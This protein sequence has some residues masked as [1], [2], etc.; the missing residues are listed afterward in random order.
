MNRPPIGQPE[1]IEEGIR[2]ILAPN[3]GPMIHWGTNTWIVGERDVAV[4]DPGPDN[5]AHLAA[6]LSAT[7]SSTITHILVTHP[8][9]DHSPLSRK[10]AKHTGAPILGF[11]APQDGRSAVME[12]LSATANVGGGEGIDMHF[13]PD[14]YVSEGDK[15]AGDN[16]TLNVTHTP[17]HFSGHLG[18]RLEDF[19]F[20]GDHVMDWA[21]TLVSPPD[22]DVAAF[23]AT[24][25]R[26][27]DMELF[28]CFPGHGAPID[29]PA[30][31]LSWLLEHRQ[32]RE[33]AI[34]GALGSTPLS[35][36]EITA[37]VYRDV[38]KS[39][40]QMA[41]RNVFA[42]LIDLWERNQIE[43]TPSLSL[44]ARFAVR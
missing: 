36:A 7:A 34:L 25:E 22:G 2:R 10:L 37:D 9:A 17:G 3:A 39:M 5:A 1:V 29:A 19:L 44:N 26:L 13:A 27:I 31:R 21:S 32:S 20:S 42:H 33:H 43:A 14:Q 40:H 18:F 15:I 38:P 6:I 24:S 41:A 30:D 16:W 12:Q 4:I 28:R 11:G 8:H 23:R 35:I